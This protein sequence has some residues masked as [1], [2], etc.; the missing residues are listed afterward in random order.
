MSSSSPFDVG[1]WRVD[2]S[3][4]RIARTGEIAELE[5]KVM[6]LLVLLSQRAGTVV[7]RTEIAESLWPGVHVNE[8]ALSRTVFKLR[9]ALGDD[10]RDPRYVET[11]PKRGVRLIAAVRE[12]EPAASKSARTPLLAGAAVMLIAALAAFALM[13][14]APAAETPSTAVDIARADALYHRFT[15]ADN[16]AALALYETAL[17]RDPENAAAMAGLANALTQRVIRFS[18]E[19]GLGAERRSLGEAIEYGWLERDDARAAIDRAAALAQAA[20]EADPGHAR[21]W[22]A[23]GLAE[24]ARGDFEASRRAHERALV[25]DPDD[26]GALVN[27]ADISQLTGR[28]SDARIY[29]A[30]AFEAMDRAYVEDAAQIGPWQAEVGFDVARRY[31]ADGADDQAE[32]WYRRVLAVDPMHVEATRAL[33]AALRRSGD[34]GQAERLCAELERRAG[35]SCE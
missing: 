12:T 32:L 8:D 7:G 34:A 29:M 27:L 33:A 10:A 19:T 14:R 35:A 3:A 22:R 28:D 2:P 17:A 15:R 20:T 4:N 16:E 1:D 9:R 6:D 18:D 31:A 24:A 21:A 23:L 25:I 30:Q 5:P 11:V 13:L 26:W